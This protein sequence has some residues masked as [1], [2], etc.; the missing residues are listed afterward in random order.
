M[1][2]SLS[3]KPPLQLGYL[4]KLISLI[5]CLIISNLLTVD[6]GPIAHHGGQFLLLM[7]V[8]A[9][10]NYALTGL[11]YY[12]FSQTWQRFIYALLCWW[13]VTIALATWNSWRTHLFLHFNAVYVPITHVLSLIHI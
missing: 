9:T 10:F 6:A 8:F 11:P 3:T 13:F 12:F 7:L 4:I 5:L 1:K 2:I